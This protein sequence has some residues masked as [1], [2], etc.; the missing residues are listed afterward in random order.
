MTVNMQS[1]IPI[2]YGLKFRDFVNNTQIANTFKLHYSYLY[3]IVTFSQHPI[4]YIAKYKH[5]L[6]TVSQISV[7]H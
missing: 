3:C 6:A 2:F 7:H 5:E 1:V 4:R